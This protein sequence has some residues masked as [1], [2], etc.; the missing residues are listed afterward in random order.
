[1]TFS[2]SPILGVYVR[3]KKVLRLED[4]IRRM[5]SLPAQRFRIDNRG[6]IRASYA[7]DIVIFD[8]NKVID[9]AT[10]EKPHAYSLGIETVLVNGVAVLE[11]GKH[12]GQKSGEIIYGKGKVN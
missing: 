7:A 4:A 5:T 1:M 8:E 2:A 12:T 6:L 3:E 9:K 10:F 11:N